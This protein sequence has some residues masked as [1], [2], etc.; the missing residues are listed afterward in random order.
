MLKTLTTLILCAV[1]ALGLIASAFALGARGDEHNWFNVTWRPGLAR[2]VLF[3]NI[4]NLHND[5]DARN[6]YLGP[7]T[8]RITIITKLYVEPWFSDVVWKEF[9]KKISGVTGKP[10]ELLTEKDVVTSLDAP[11]YI[12]LESVNE[13]NPLTLGKTYNESGIILYKQ[14][15]ESFSEDTPET[16]EAYIVSTLLHEF[17]HQLGLAHNEE[18]GCLMNSHAETGGN[19]KFIASEVVTNFC[20]DEIEQ[21]SKIKSE[22]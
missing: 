21:I 12:Y 18:P 6:E 3:R 19:A 14:G 13:E 9:S 10:V 20:P 1:I 7:K 5:G 4:F 15:L 22:L 11:V 2:R 17:G 8:K 16:K